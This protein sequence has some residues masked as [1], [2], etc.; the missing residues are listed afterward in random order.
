MD[1]NDGTFPIQSECMYEAVRGNSGIILLV[2]LPD[3]A[4][5]YR[6]K[7]TI[8]DLLWEKFQWFHKHINGAV[9]STNDN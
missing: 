1:D 7:E 6:A 3:E 4:H 5:G 8:E 9:L 2:F